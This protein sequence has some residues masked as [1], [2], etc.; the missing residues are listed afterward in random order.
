M[1]DKYLYSE[2]MVR[3]YDVIYNS[4]AIRGDRNFY[5]E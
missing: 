3:F 5:I 2:T 1:K 4:I